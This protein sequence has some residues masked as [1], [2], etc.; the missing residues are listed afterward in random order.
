MA[1]LDELLLGVWREAARHTDITT[2]TTN[3]ALL[4]AP[5]VPLQQVLVRRIE[6]ERS[7]LETVG[8]GTEKISPWTLGERSECNLINL[9]RLLAWCHRMTK[10][11]ECGAVVPRR[12]HED[13]RCTVSEH[14]TCG[15]ILPLVTGTVFYTPSADAPG[16]LGPVAAGK[17]TTVGSVSSR[18]PRSG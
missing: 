10:W 6:P 12:G 13:P 11:P 5:Y 9:Q 3:I 16:Y 7:C 18:S 8:I 17:R 15:L 2:S 4:L 1:Q 14:G